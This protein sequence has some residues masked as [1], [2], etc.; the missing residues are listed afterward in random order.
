M[1]TNDDGPDDRSNQFFREIDAIIAAKKFR[2]ENPY[3]LYLIRVLF[4]H[5]DGLRRP[6]VLHMI[7]RSRKNAGLEIPKS[8]DDVVQSVLEQHC[9]DSQVF[10][11]RGVPAEEALFY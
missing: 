3:V 1:T 11:K 7:R 9:A 6:I 8:F 4:P 5:S 2:Q 10:K